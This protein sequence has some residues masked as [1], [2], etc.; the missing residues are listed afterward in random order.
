MNL[1]ISGS[2]K[3]DKPGVGLLRV[4]TKESIF[5]SIHVIPI[6]IWPLFSI[7]ALYHSGSGPIIL[8][9]LWGE[10]MENFEFGES[11][12]AIFVIVG[13]KCAI[14][15]FEDGLIEIDREGGYFG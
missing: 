9:F 10:D 3:A 15:L 7:W 11:G 6:I 8:P 1:S 12:F 4:L 13:D 14:G 5:P 2:L